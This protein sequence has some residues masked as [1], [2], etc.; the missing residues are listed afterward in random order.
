MAPPVPILPNT[1]DAK[2]PPRPTRT[3]STPRFS[4]TILGA[5]VYVTGMLWLVGRIV[6]GW[7]VSARLSRRATTI[8][9]APLM[10]RLQK[11]ALAT[12]LRRRPHLLEATGLLVPVTTGIVKPVVF[13]PT[14]WRDWPA[15]KLD[16]VLVHELSHIA[17][18]DAL[19]QRLSLLYRALYWFSPFSWWLRRHLVV[20]GDRSSDE[21]VLAAGIDRVTYAETL[22]GFFAAIRDVPRRAD[23]H[24][25]MAS[26]PSAQQRVDHVLKCDGTR[27]VRLTTFTVFAVIVAVAPILVAVTSAR[28]TLV[29]TELSAAPASPDLTPAFGMLSPR[30]VEWPEPIRVA[31]PQQRTPAAPSA[32][33]DRIYIGPPGHDDLAGRQSIVFLFDLRTLPNF[34]LKHAADTAAIYVDN[35]WRRAE[36]RTDIFHV[37]AVQ[38]LGATLETVQDFTWDKAAVQAAIKR[39]GDGDTTVG[40]PAEVRLQTLAAMCD[41]L[42]QQQPERKVFYGSNL[43]LDFMELID[44]KAV[45]YFGNGSIRGSDTVADLARLTSACTRRNLAFYT[46]GGAAFFDI[47]YASPP[48]IAVSL[49][50]VR[51]QVGSPVRLSGGQSATNSGLVQLTL[52]NNSPKMVTSLTLGTLVRPNDRKL[53]TPQVFT[54]PVHYGFKI[55]PRHVVSL[56]M[57]VIKQNVL[58]GLSIDGA[59]G[60]VG[61]VGVEFDDGSTWTYDLQSTGRFQDDSD[62]EPPS[63]STIDQEHSDARRDLMNGVAELQR[64]LDGRL[65]PRALVRGL[66]TATGID[67]SDP[68]AA[69]VH[70]LDESGLVPPKLDPIL[71]LASWRLPEMRVVGVD[72]VVDDTGK[73]MRVRI[74]RSVDRSPNG[75]D[76]NALDLVRAASF[77]PARL[78]GAAV[79]VLVRVPVLVR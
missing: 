2:E 57:R 31:P 11:C 42:A 49:V 52:Q 25:A 50:V 23:W 72:A 43:P 27:A 14:D 64:A 4:W 45:L 40:A 63:P 34:D 9:D 6:V 35:L 32:T 54:T 18:R 77:T 22:L 74:A 55:P 26:G 33:L 78:N 28:A 12:G 51:H 79:S 1:L 15:V 70:R 41:S 53:P 76:E 59:K 67:A 38:T 61:I 20:L 30:A 7:I 71:S 65:D 24:V 21:A 62:A 8:A 19:V 39:V 16:A 10:A 29:S 75:I 46:I 56:G 68:F 13:L 17:R 60:E 73:V 69:G 66:L 44:A 58:Q 47:A 48:G 3:A 5:V 36:S 37:G